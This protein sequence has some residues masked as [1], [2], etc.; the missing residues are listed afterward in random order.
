[1][2]RKSILIIL[3]LMLV[4][5]GWGGATMSSAAPLP[6]TPTA[7]ANPLTGTW[8]FSFGTMTLTQTGARVMGTYQWYGGGDSGKIR[9]IFLSGL[10][11]FSGLWKSDGGSLKS[12]GFLR[13]RLAPD[14]G[15]FNGIF[16][17][18]NTQ[19]P[20]CGVRAG[21]VL[22]AGCGFSG[23]WQLR[24]GNPPGVTGQATLIQAGPILTGT[25]TNSAGQTGQI[26]E[27]LIVT[28]SLTEG[29]VNGTWRVGPGQPESFDWRL[30]LTTGTTFQGRRDPGN[31]DWC[32]W[33]EGVN[34]TEPCGW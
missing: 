1:M 26:V 32:G 6:A 5:L 12:Q 24:F 2:P 3:F 34:E 21:S 33:R 17:R 29:R 9:G 28:H 15:S 13:L 27:G 18:A 31:S 30:N 4:L 11:Q 16:E 20:W 25:F 19:L 7:S 23:E 10:N 14:G 22:P 8:E